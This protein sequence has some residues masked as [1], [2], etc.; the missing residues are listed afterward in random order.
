M[1]TI[2]IK[3]GTRSTT[4]KTLCEGCCSAQIV[5][6]MSEGQQIVFCHAMEQQLSYNVEE[7]NKYRVWGEQS[8]YEMQQI[9]TIIAPTSD[10]IGFYKP[11]KYQ[12]RFPDRHVLPLEYED[13]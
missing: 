4:Q 1:S 13:L 2:R 10:G 11:G 8:L 5:K 3:G 9:A 12:Q 7:C 6:G